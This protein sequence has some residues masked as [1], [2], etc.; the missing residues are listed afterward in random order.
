MN[1]WRWYLGSLKHFSVTFFLTL[2]YFADPLF[3]YVCGIVIGTSLV[4]IGAAFISLWF[5]LL[6]P[7]A[8]TLVA[9]AY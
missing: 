8:I 4:I 5:L 3:E 6:I 1:F 2:K 9:H 7:V